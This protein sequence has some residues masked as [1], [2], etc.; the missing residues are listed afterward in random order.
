MKLNFYMEVAGFILAFFLTIVTCAP[1]YVIDLKD[2]LYVKMT[3][4]IIVFTTMNLLSYWIIR[5]NVCQLAWIAECGIYMSFWLLVWFVF[6]L[7]L[8]MN[9]CFQN[10]NRISVAT[11]ILYGLPSFV[12][13]IL[14]IINLGNNGVFE[15]SKVDSNLAIVFNGMYPISYFLAFFSLGVGLISNFLLDD[16]YI[17]EKE[18]RAF[19]FAFVILAITYYIQFRFKAI[20]SFGFGCAFVLILLYIYSYHCNNKRD[21]LTHLASGYSFRKMIQYRAGNEQPMFVILMNINDFKYVNKVYGYQTGDTFI[22]EIG[23][24]LKTIFPEPCIARYGGDQ[25]GMIL[26]GADE[27]VLMQAIETIRNRFSD[28]WKAGKVE[29][30]L[31]MSMVAAQCPDMCNGLEETEAVLTY[32]LKEAR[33]KKQNCFLLYS[34]A[35]RMKLE[36]KKTIASLLKNVIDSQNVE[37]KYQPIYDATKNQYSRVQAMFL[38]KD[39]KLQEISQDEFYPVAEEFGYLIEVGYVLLDKVCQFLHRYI[40]SGKKPPTIS[41]RFAR[42]QLMDKDVAERMMEILKHYG[43][44][45][46]M[47]AIEIPENVFLVRY[48]NVKRKINRMSGLGFRFYLDGFGTGILDLV[49][50]MELPFELIKIDAGLIREAEKNEPIFLLVSAITAVFEENGQKLVATGIDTERLKDITDMLFMDYMQGDYFSVSVPEKEVC[51][52]LEKENLFKSRMQQIEEWTDNNEESL[53]LAE[54]SLEEEQMD[55]I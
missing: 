52:L 26:D 22:K 13:L 54:D 11:Y 32:L 24:F 10:K 23:E 14:L 5:N 3:H 38:L 53:W 12:N 9:E 16:K 49:H 4:T 15:L 40:E 55:G 31:S 17:L 46:D 21:N 48:E 19:I 47:I 36:R 45:P 50:L 33:D 25:F 44:S 8:Y 18:K 34:E 6:L 20:A 41:V 42:Q 51:D 1:Y 29:Y 37:V 35:D 7:N 43:L 27:E 2:R 30:K 28:K 39:S